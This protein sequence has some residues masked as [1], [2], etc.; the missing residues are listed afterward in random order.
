[1][2]FLYCMLLFIDEIFFFKEKGAC[3]S[4]MY[5]GYFTMGKDQLLL[6]TAIHVQLYCM[7]QAIPTDKK[8]LFIDRS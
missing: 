5:S 2:N 3:N 8:K 1:M 7:G 4:I 6:L